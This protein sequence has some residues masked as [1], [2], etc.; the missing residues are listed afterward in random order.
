[1]LN[2]NGVESSKHGLFS[3]L[4]EHIIPRGV[5]ILQCADDTILYL[6]H[7]LEG[8]RNMKM[9]LYLFEMIAGL[10]INFS[11][12]EILMINDEENWGQQYAEIFNC[13]VGLFPVK[14]LGVP[15]SPSRL[16]LSDWLPLTKKC[17][18]RLEVWKGGSLTMAGRSTLI[19]ACLN[20]APMYHMSVYL[21]LKTTVKEIDKIRRTFFW[22]GGGT[23]RK[24]HLV[25]WVKIC[26]HKKKGGV[27]IKDLTKLNISF[28]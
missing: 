18:K 17:Y 7:D 14:Y 25:N 6:K 21:L 23:K 4:A 10:K 16:H 22:Q 3:G 19:C 8:A 11:K 28:V 20:N 9:L 15:I 5:D 2:K 12:S 27:G 24:Y 26:R 13:Q 1:L